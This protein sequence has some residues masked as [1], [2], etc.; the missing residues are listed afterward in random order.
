M[1]TPGK[2][3]LPM[4]NLKT[5]EILRVCNQSY[6]SP[7]GVIEGCLLIAHTINEID[8]RALGEKIF[9]VHATV[10]IPELQRSSPAR[11]KLMS[12]DEQTFVVHALS[13]VLADTT[14]TF[15]EIDFLSAAAVTAHG[16]RFSK[17]EFLLALDDVIIRRAEAALRAEDS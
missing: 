2:E 6:V 12:I 10:N 9:D 3:K 1:V 8:F 14:L 5:F 7:E 13:P 11:T 17:S 16:L 4:R 15:P